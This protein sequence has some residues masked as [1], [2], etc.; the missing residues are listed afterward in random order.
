MEVDGK[1]RFREKAEE[2]WQLAL[3][4]LKYVLDNA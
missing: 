1:N 2:E 3:T 4:F